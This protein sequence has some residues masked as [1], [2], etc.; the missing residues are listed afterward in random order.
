ME[1]ASILQGLFLIICSI[2]GWSIKK[3]LQDELR[4]IRTEMEKMTKSLD[5]MSCVLDSHVSSKHPHNNFEIVLDE[6]FV[7]KDELKHALE[8]KETIK[9]LN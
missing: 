6:K 2:V 8:T 4:P 9:D 3:V 5:H 7:T 1:I